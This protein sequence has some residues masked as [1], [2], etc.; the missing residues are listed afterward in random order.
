VNAVPY[1]APFA[2]FD[3]DGAAFSEADWKACRKKI[4]AEFEL[5]GNATIPWKDRTFDKS[6]LLQLLD[7][8][9]EPEARAFHLA[10]QNDVL[11]FRLL[12]TFD[13]LVLADKTTE[14]DPQL[15][16]RC[17]PYLA[18]ACGQAICNAFQRANRAALMAVYQPHPLIPAPVLPH[19]WN[20]LHV[21]LLRTGEQLL[22]ETAIHND[23]KTVRQLYE[24]HMLPVSAGCMQ[25]LPVH[26]KSDC[27][28][29]IRA[30]VQLSWQLPHNPQQAAQVCKLING[31]HDILPRGSAA[32][33]NEI[34]AL[35]NR[36]SAAELLPR[37]RSRILLVASFLPILLLLLTSIIFVNGGG[38]TDT[39]TPQIFQVFRTGTILITML[40]VGFLVAAFRYI[41]R[42]R[43]TISGWWFFGLLLLNVLVFPLFWLFFIRHPKD[44]TGNV[45]SIVLIVITLAL[46]FVRGALQG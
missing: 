28:M 33:R 10:V 12:T 45:L 26:L 41:W 38:N 14:H 44:R 3:L 7:E 22:R 1:I 9:H 35:Y 19:I 25:L 40:S 43:S 16:R 20:P 29:Y 23:R 24:K 8:V 5:S 37:T 34:P 27:E 2:L 31:L 46:V 11:L 21:Y 30:L 32:L 18:Y 15:L 39:V 6:T 13:P 42:N 36:L 4:L 17:L